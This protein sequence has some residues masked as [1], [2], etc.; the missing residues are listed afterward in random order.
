MSNTIGYD[1]EGFANS[2][3]ISSST[4]PIAGTE[5]SDPVSLYLPFDSD[6]NDDSDNNHT[7]T[8]GDGAAISSTQSKFGGNSLNLDGTNDYL[9]VAASTD[10]DFGTGLFTIEGWIYSQRSSSDNVYSQGIIFSGST[11]AWS[12]SLGHLAPSYPNNHHTIQFYRYASG[13]D[14]Y[15]VQTAQTV[16]RNAWHHFAVVR[17]NSTTIKIYVDGVLSATESSVAASAE[18]NSGGGAI[19]IGRNYGTTNTV[20][21]V[22]GY[23]DDLRIS[24]GIARYT[25]DFIPPSQA[26]GAKLTG[27]NETN[28]TT[29]LTAFYAP[30]DSDLNDD[31]T[32]A[33]TGTAGGSAAISSTQAKF[34]GN[35]LYMGTG[36]HSVT[37]PNTTDFDFGTGPYTVE[38]WAYATATAYGNFESLMGFGSSG[39]H[40]SYV[41]GDSSNDGGYFEFGGS[42]GGYTG[43]DGVGQGAAAQWMHI[44][45]TRDDNNTVRYFVNGTIKSTSANNTTSRVSGGD[46][47]KI[48]YGGVG[49]YRSFQGYLDDIRILKGYAKYTADF[50][51]PTSAV[52]TSVSETVNDL[53]V[54]YLP[55]DDS[56]MEDQ[57]RNHSIIKEG[58]VAISTSVKKL[59][60]SSAYFATNDDELH[61]TGSKFD[62]GTSFTI[63]GWYYLTDY[64]VHSVAF[65]YEQV[66]L[67]PGKDEFLLTLGISGN[68]SAGQ[69]RARLILNDGAENIWVGGDSG[70]NY[71][72]SPSLNTW[73]HM[74]FVRDGASLYLFKDGVQLGI[75]QTLT[76][77]TLPLSTSGNN[78][79][80][81]GGSA[82]SPTPYS[83]HG[84]KGYIDDFRIV[85]GVALYT[86]NFTPPTSPVGLA[87]ESGG[88]TTNVVDNKFLSSVWDSD[89]VSEKMADGTWIRNDSDTGGA[90]V[91]KG[92]GLEVAGHRWYSAPTSTSTTLKSWGAGGGGNSNNPG[93]GGGFTVAEYEINPG[94]Q[95]TVQVGGGGGSDTRSSGPGLGGTHGGGTAT[96]SGG[97]GGGY[98]GVFIGP[99]SQANALVI[100]GG[101]GGDSN[102]DPSPSVGGTGGGSTGGTGSS[103]VGGGGGSQVAG[104]LG[105]NGA[106]NGSALQGGGPNG[107]V[108]SGGGGGYYGGGA[109][110][111]GGSS[112]G[113]GG[114]GSGFFR[115]GS[116]PPAVTYPGTDAS[117]TNASGGSVAGS[118]DPN[119]VSGKGNGGNSAGPGTSYDAEDGLVVITDPSGTYTFTS[120]GTHTVS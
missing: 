50:A 15:N 102:H 93:G 77:S 74:A 1:L 82:Q 97:G 78:T 14:N 2:S 103:P 87:V 12:V 72:S 113:G 8:A 21:F 118:S 55:F 108:T 101:G 104:G 56:S 30:F 28:T 119:Y 22:N 33:G 106:E 96:S 25:K 94:T 32:N 70:S 86:S 91:I 120:P 114:G 18:F 44:A 109:G 31:S 49:S 107:P 24:K 26:V 100:A 45:F 10:F 79:L 13:S 117:T 99:A 81:I 16:T 34:G 63:E 71:T 7:V 84:M 42:L 3:V 58:T 11:G 65:Q 73:F 9:S 47:F 95:L 75:T 48:G 36:N 35:S 66:G 88:V 27:S 46:T 62:L 105:G 29:A 59:G 54:L 57:A 53:T 39:W 41:P 69:I 20:H 60:T 17:E 51:P 38:F 5:L 67:L 76:N 90:T 37:Y 19:E 98:S 4:T 43:I 92:A 89:D 111:D 116:L 68:G 61:I 80:V 64:T 40:V 115:T 6:L 85:D 112:H 110:G 83:N 23:I 52:G